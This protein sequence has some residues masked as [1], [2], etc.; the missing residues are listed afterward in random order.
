MSKF[1]S[2]QKKGQ[3]QMSTAALPDIVFM[4]LFFFMVAASIKTDNWDKYIKIERPKATELAEIERKEFVNYIYIG[5][6]N[7]AYAPKLGNQPILVINDAPATLQD[8]APYIN[9]FRKNFKPED[10]EQL[11]TQ[12]TI[13]K[14]AKMGFIQ[15]VKEQLGYAKQFEVSYAGAEGDPMENLAQQ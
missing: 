12:L 5:T 2:E 13:D 9:E 8:I 15:D 10:I 11:V 1:K 6:P 4:L 3:P 14:N 7:E